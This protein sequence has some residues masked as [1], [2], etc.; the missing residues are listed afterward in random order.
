MISTLDGADVVDL[1]DHTFALVVQH[2][3]EFSSELQQK[4]YDSIGDILKTHS[5]L[6]REKVITVPS[7]ETIPL[8]SKFEAEI[9]RLKEHERPETH[10]KAFT[11]RLRDENA[12]I[13]WQA[14]KELKDW[15]EIHQSLVHEIAISEQSK[16]VISDLLRAL[17]DVCARPASNEHDIANLGT[18]CI[19]II[20]CL[21]PNR[22]EV[23]SSKRRLL[24]LSNFDK[25]SEVIDW[26]ALLLE[27]IIVPAFKSSTNARAQGFLAYVMQELVRFCEFNEVASAKL[28]ASQVNPAYSRWF[29]MP[30]SVRNTLTP[31]LTSRYFL[32]A[33]T[34]TKPEPCTYP[35]Y[36]TGTTASSWLREWVYDMLWRGKGV[37]AEMVFPYLA[38]ISRGHDLSLPAFL[39]PYVALNIVLGGT[40]R[41]ADEISAELLVVL[42]TESSVDSER[43][44]LKQCSEV[45]ADHM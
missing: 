29:D 9:Q 13:V 24:L 10:L 19:G 3:S 28:R 8:M 5:S 15:L 33:K 43:E 18:R 1:V 25:A 41:E 14:L 7:L 2:W 45:R 12:S 35:I 38:R 4:T 17:L 42:S 36:S 34:A 6:I 26:V 40:I 11:E 31:F 21:D 37:N 22:V 30:E 20:G 32:S 39:L 16:D 23:S 27:D 44:T